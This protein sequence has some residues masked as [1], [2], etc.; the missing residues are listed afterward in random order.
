MNQQDKRFEKGEETYRRVI[1]AAL[2]IIS[3]QGV[4]GITASKLSERSKIS[5]SS[6]FHHFSSTQE[7]PAA[8]LK[9]IMEMMIRPFE[10]PG[11]NVTLEQ[12]LIDLG[13]ALFNMAEEQRYV[14]KAFFSF[15]HESM[16]NEVLRG[17][18]K[19]Y[20]YASK[21]DLKK[22]LIQALDEWKTTPHD[23][24]EKNI[25]ELEAEQM[26]LLLISTLDG[27]GLHLLMGESV[28]SYKNAWQMQVKSLRRY[29]L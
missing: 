25:R 3:E 21:S 16:F 10:L 23:E 18:I 19:T 24:E 11:S 5:K 26:S 1:Q 20:L 8:V 28:L 29:F 9:T 6:V 13:D 27:I 17:M 14:Y 12:F 4:S 22:L 7:I 2:E 15:Y